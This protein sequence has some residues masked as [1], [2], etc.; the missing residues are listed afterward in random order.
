MKKTKNDLYQVS[1]NITNTLNEISEIDY[2]LDENET[3]TLKDLQYKFKDWNDR[4]SDNRYRVAIIG[5]EKAGKSTFANALLRKNFLPEDEGR[6]TF[7]TTTIEASDTEDI[8]EI[9]FFSKEEFIN[10][11][12]ALC[13]EI[14]FSCDYN[15]V[16]LSQF[17]EFCN[18][19]SPSEAQ[20]NNVDDIKAIITNKEK[21]EKYLSGKKEILKKEQLE[22]VKS[23]ITDEI[24]A[25]AVKHI[26]IKSTQFKKQKDIIIYDVPGFDSPTKLHLDQAKWYMR[27]ADIVIMLISI[28][29]KVSFVKAQADFLNDTK[30]KYG[31]KLADKLIIIASKFD[32]HIFDDKISSEEKIGKF[33]KILVDELKKY[34]L[35]KEKNIFK[36]SALGFLEK[37]EIVNTKYAYPKLQKHNFSDGIETIEKRLQEFLDGEALKLL[38]EKFEIDKSEVNTFLL[39][40]KDKYNPNKD[41]KKKRSEEFNLIDKKWDEIK[42]KLQERLSNYQEEI[43]EKDDFNFNNSIS[44]QVKSE[45]IEEF[46]KRLN[47]EILNAKSTIVGG[48]AKVEQATKVNDKV[49]EKIYVDS[50]NKIVTLSTDIITTKNQEQENKIL[51]YIIN[52]IFDNYQISNEIK[53]ILSKTIENI[54]NDF[55]YDSKSYKPLILRFLNNVFEI[56]I[57]NRITNEEKDARVERFK[58]YRMDIESLLNYNN[59][60]DDELGFYEQKMIQQILVQKTECKLSNPTI[61]AL[62]KYAN[63]ATSYDEVEKEIS[64][65]LDN[66]SEIF[67]TTLLSAIDIESPFKASLNDQIEAILNDIKE[68]SDSKLKKFIIDY[69]EIIAREEYSKLEID[70]ELVK[71]LENI[72]DNIEKL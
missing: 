43:K 69:I 47:K 25:R 7:T 34:H 16:T 68:N 45:W 27:N 21:I 19:L 28:A 23:F 15:N 29:D 40:F 63:I 8:A 35:Y 13:E 32:V 31:Q 24:K 9:Q 52:I 12:Y 65:D 62:L 57:L 14:K 33:Y 17:N 48:R 71:K 26:F 54:T 70:K 11:F 30:D 67:N 2:I 46:K 20:S 22:N 72:I 64:N 60:Y 59:D 58:E 36:V 39:K 55:K 5:T 3:E 49:R 61:Q 56:L 38:N 6:C 44:N 4:L 1:K 53:E 41:E 51:D 18:T 50:L 10:K 37:Y 66:L 42:S